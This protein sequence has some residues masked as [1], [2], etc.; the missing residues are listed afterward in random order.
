MFSGTLCR[1]H[2]GVGLRLCKIVRALLQALGFKEEFLRGPSRSSFAS[3]TLRTLRL[4]NGLMIQPMQ[5]AWRQCG[6]KLCSGLGMNG[7]G[8]ETTK[9]L[10]VECTADGYSVETSNSSFRSRLCAL[11]E[12]ALKE[13]TLEIWKDEACINF[14][15]AYICISL[16]EFLFTYMIIYI[17][18]YIY[19]QIYLCA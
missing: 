8:T 7:T 2:Q 1:C 14:I 16:Y 3:L 6:I 10:H 11:K 13:G 17:Y 19:I 18:T 4:S 9:Q 5:T 15:A 12:C